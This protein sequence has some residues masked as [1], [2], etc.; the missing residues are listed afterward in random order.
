MGTYRRICIGAHLLALLDAMGAALVA[1]A[2]DDAVRPAE[3]EESGKDA[4]V[5][6]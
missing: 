1:A 3:M 6:V 5:V 4:A 2:D